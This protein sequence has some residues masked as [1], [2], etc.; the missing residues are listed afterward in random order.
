[1]ILEVG[2]L[3]HPIQLSARQQ[4]MKDEYKTF[5]CS[6]FFCSSGGIRS[7]PD[8]SWKQQLHRQDQ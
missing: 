7:E 1:M 4:G 6:L 8:L 3:P 5:I 2:Q